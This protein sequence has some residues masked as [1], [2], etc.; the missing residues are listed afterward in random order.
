MITRVFAKNFR[1]ISEVDVNLNRLTILVGQNSSG[2]SNFLD[3]L[4]FFSDALRKGIQVAIDDVRQGIKTIRRWSPSRPYDIRLELEIDD[5][6]KAKKIKGRKLLDH[7]EQINATYRI[8]I[9]SAKYIEPEEYSFTSYLIKREKCTIFMGNKKFEY[10]IYNG[11]FLKRPEGFIPFRK[12]AKEVLSRPSQTALFLPFLVYLKPYSYL[13]KLLISMFFYNIYPNIIKTPR[14]PGIEYPLESHGR[15]IASVIRK[16]Q[17]DKSPW[18]DQIKE[19]LSK[20]V[21][22]LYDFQVSPVGGFLTIKFKHKSDKS[23]PHYFEANQESDGTLRILGI[24]VSLFQ[25]P[26]PYLL[27]IEEPEI[28]VHPGILGLIADL[29]KEAS[30]RRSQIIVTTHSPDL[31]SKFDADDLRLVEWN[32]RE[33]TTINRIHDSQIDIINDKLFSAGD[34]LRIEGLRPSKRKEDL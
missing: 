29:I 11:E 12:D 27:A 16:M 22:D 9:K 26:P 28:T 15:N 31:I 6:I 2:K 3:I 20:V 19:V 33:G 13:Y 24:L 5:I 25:D 14:E 1:S 4:R 10:E 8:E 32:Y 7:E 30:K 21:P 23:K 18:L 17:R 34:L